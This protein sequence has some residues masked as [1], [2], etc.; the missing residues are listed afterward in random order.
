M[1]PMLISPNFKFIIINI[2][3]QEL[4]YL[5]LLLA[6]LEIQPKPWQLVFVIISKPN[7]LVPIRHSHA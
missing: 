5:K 7:Q 4:S 6:P 1:S 2:K 3:S